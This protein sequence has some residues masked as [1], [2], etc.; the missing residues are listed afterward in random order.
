MAKGLSNQ[1]LSF[2]KH[3][4]HFQDDP[5]IIN[6]SLINNPDSFIKYDFGKTFLHELNIKVQFNTDH[7]DDDNE[8]TVSNKI[9]VS[10]QLS[11]VYVH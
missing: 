3:K 2:F 7:D 8:N 9:S 1:H 4:R 11:L 5:I 10:D 6:I